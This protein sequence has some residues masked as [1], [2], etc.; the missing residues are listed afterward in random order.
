MRFLAAPLLAAIAVPASAAVPVQRYEIVRTYPHDPGA[1]TQ[2][3]FFRDGYLYESTGQEG[4][5]TVRKVNLADGRV[6]QS[7]PIP[8]SQFGE[9]STD[10]GKEIVSLTWRHG[11][12]YRWDRA[13]LK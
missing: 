1:F 2:G 8:P 9:G 7:A 12:G 4:E 3:L 10:W 6:L 11:I 5:S 13:T